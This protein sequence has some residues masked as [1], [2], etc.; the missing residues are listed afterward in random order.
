MSEFA[1]YVQSKNL[2]VERIFHCS[3]RIEGHSVADRNLRVQ[4]EGLRRDGK[5]GKY[6]DAGV[7]KPR[8]GRG[9][10]RQRIEAAL[11]GQPLA[12]RVR[13]KLVRALAALGAA[14]ADEL[15]VRK[16]F[17]DVHARHAPAPT[18]G[19]DAAA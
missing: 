10:S 1:K 17:G 2:T 5:G 16:L 6:A 9:V 4:R 18:S 3:A 15:D 19:G 7:A 11:A 12:A 14:S 8:S 13:G